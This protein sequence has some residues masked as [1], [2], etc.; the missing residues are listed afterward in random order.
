MWRSATKSEDVSDSVSNRRSA[1]ELLAQQTGL[2]DS[3]HLRELGLSQRATE[4]VW[5][6]EPVVQ[7]PDFGR[8]LVPVEAYLALIA[9][10]TYCDQCADRV[11]LSSR[12]Q[13]QPHPRRRNTSPVLE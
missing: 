1:V 3:T 7:L 6:N 2:L 12:G 4:A 8:P 11:R 9:G 10:H 5:R 13:R